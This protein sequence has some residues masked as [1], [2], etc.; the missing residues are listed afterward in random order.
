M[1]ENHPG[2][3]QPDRAA[4]QRPVEST[5]TPAEPSDPAFGPADPAFGPADPAFESPN[6]PPAAAYEPP[7]QPPAPTVRTA[8]RAD[9]THWAERAVQPAVVLPG[10]RQLAVRE[11][12]RASVLAVR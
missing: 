1:T 3:D 6:Q 8:E 9:C 10:A 4:D 7:N 11:H 12:R 5:A 2:S